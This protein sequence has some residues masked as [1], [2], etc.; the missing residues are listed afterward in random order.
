MR[1][2]YKHD[3]KSYEKDIGRVAEIA[4]DK[5]REEDPDIELMRFQIADMHEHKMIVVT[6]S[7]WKYNNGDGMDYEDGWL[8]VVMIRHLNNL[9]DACIDV[10]VLEN[11]FSR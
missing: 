10:M 8:E 4:L 6:L 7:V 9:S 1:R 5:L 2:E 11:H 3:R